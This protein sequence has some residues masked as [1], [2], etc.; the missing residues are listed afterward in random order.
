MQFYKTETILNRIE[1]EMIL[2]ICNQ[3]PILYNKY[4]DRVLDSWHHSHINSQYILDRENIDI[5]YKIID[6]LIENIKE[7]KNNKDK[8]QLNIYNSQKFFRIKNIKLVNNVCFVNDIELY[9]EKIDEIIDWSKDVAWAKQM[10]L[11]L[12]GNRLIAIIDKDKMRIRTKGK[13]EIKT[14]TKKG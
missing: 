2:Y 7:Y 5:D 12:I 1:T 8:V 14:K 11:Q 3:Y 4:R 13:H 6:A 9:F 10:K